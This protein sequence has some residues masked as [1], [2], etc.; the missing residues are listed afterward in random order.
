VERE[1]VRESTIHTKERFS[2]LFS[3]EKSEVGCIG[4][5]SLSGF[6]TL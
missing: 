5:L 3:V 1:R 6:L 2:L 4:A